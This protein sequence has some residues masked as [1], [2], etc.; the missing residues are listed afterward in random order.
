MCPCTSVLIE[1]YFFKFGYCIVVLCVPMCIHVAVFCYEPPDG[2]VCFSFHT[3]VCVGTFRFVEP[4]F[5]YRLGGLIA[6]SETNH[7]VLPFLPPPSLPLFPLPLTLLPLTSTLLLPLTFIPQPSLQSLL[8]LFLMPPQSRASKR[9]KP[10]EVLSAI[11]MILHLWMPFI[12]K[13]L[14]AQR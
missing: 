6:Q 14:S 2:V 3:T 7:R 8:F 13:L 11:Y 12:A 4:S 5:V 9:H 10:V 1:D